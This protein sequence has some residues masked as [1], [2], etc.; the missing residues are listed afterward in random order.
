MSCKASNCKTCNYK[1]CCCNRVSFGDGEKGVKGEQG[2]T[3]DSANV[4]STNTIMAMDGLQG[5]IG[6]IGEKGYPGTLFSPTETAVKGDKGGNGPSSQYG[7]LTFNFGDNLINSYH[8]PEHLKTNTTDDFHEGNSL[9][10][11]LGYIYNASINGNIVEVDSTDT[12]TKNVV[13]AKNYINSSIISGTSFLTT[14]RSNT[15]VPV[16]VIA[17]TLSWNLVSRAVSANSVSGLP[18]VPFDSI[19]STDGSVDCYNPDDFPASIGNLAFVGKIRDSTYQLAYTL[20]VRIENHST[21]VG[22]KTEDTLIKCSDWIE[23]STLSGAIPSLSAINWYQKESIHT[24]NGIRYCLISTNNNIIEAN[25]AISIIYTFNKIDKTN[26]I[27]NCHYETIT[28]NPLTQELSPPT[29]SQLSNLEF[30]FLNVSFNI[31]VLVPE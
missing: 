30:K 25:T 22:Y 17:S 2:D 3:G 12:I 31:T 27:T 7:I 9:S 6:E 14:L 28:A 13:E 24:S 19:I 21:N 29:S 1:C 20:F 10:F 18:L 15:I 4:N 5:S 11:V 16:L 23:I 26:D 8:V